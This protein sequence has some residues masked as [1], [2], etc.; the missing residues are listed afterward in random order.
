MKTVTCRCGAIYQRLEEKA[1]FRDNGN[2]N[3]Y[4][5]RKELESWSGARII[6]FKLLKRPETDTD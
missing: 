2:F 4:V 3:C 6:I 5:C 1:S